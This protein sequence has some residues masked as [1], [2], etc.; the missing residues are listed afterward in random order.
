MVMLLFVSVITCFKYIAKIRAFEIQNEY[1]LADDGLK[2]L[3]NICKNALQKPLV[4]P[5]F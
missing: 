4:H 5:K 1:I 3:N 2:L